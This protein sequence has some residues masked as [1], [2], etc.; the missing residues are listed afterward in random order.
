[1]GLPRRHAGKYL[2]AS[3]NRASCHS[4]DLTCSK[5]WKDPEFVT[6]DIPTNSDVYLGTCV[7]W[8]TWLQ[9][10]LK[11]IGADQ[12]YIWYSASLQSVGYKHTVTLKHFQL[13]SYYSCSTF[14]SFPHS[15]PWEKRYIYIQYCR[16]HSDAFSDQILA[17]LHSSIRDWLQLPYSS[18]PFLRQKN[19]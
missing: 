9:R 3:F 8:G 15:L 12:L 13:S 1:M 10:I 16:F 4:A 6:W 5:Y 19:D 18:D 2:P 17:K 7:N 11:V 14:P